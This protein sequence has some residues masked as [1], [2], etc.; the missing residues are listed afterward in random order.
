M[1]SNSMTSNGV[2]AIKIHWYD[3]VKVM[4]RAREEFGGSLSEHDLL[5]TCFPG[6]RCIF[7]RREDRVRQVISFLRAMQ[8]MQWRRMADEP[9]SERM[10]RF[11]IDLDQVDPLVRVFAEQE[12]Q[13]REFFSRNGLPAC[14]V[15]YE[16]LVRDYETTTLDALDHLGVTR[17]AGLR[18]GPPRVVRQSDELT[19]RAVAMYLERK[20]SDDYL[21][22]AV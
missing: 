2:C 7:I 22:E 21:A 3:F 8:S 15:V 18:L 9:V 4:H 16:D 20:Q 5:E 6:L 1:A 10:A 19:E 14:E 12:A 11:K 17:P 13:W